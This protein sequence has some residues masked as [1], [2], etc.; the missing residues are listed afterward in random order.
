MAYGAV[1][2]IQ[3]GL[4]RAIAN[5][6]LWLHESGTYVKLTEAAALLAELDRGLT[7]RI[8][9]LFVCRWFS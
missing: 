8:S 3:G 9:Q 2:R 1:R 4:D 6:R 5:G 7:C